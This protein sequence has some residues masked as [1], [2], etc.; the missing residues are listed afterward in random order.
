MAIPLLIGGAAIAS[1]VWGAKKHYDAKE[2]R[3]KAERVIR[4]ATEEFL[5]AQ[6]K[7]VAE[8]EALKQSA[9]DLA[10]LRKLV[11][12]RHM[13][14][15]SDQAS[16]LVNLDYEMIRIDARLPASAL[17]TLPEIEADLKVWA[18][19]PT[20]GVQGLALGLMGAA[21]AGSLATSI[22]VAST[23]TAI[24]SLSGVAATNA[25][26]AWL[27]GGSLAAGG[28][29]MAGG[30]AVLGGAVAGPLVAI[31][32][33]AA[34]KKAQE[35]LTQAYRQ[36]SEI[37]AATQDVEN[38]RVATAMIQTRVNELSATIQALI[39]RFEE[40]T[41]RLSSF[42]QRKADEKRRLERDSAERRVAYSKVN[43]FIRFFNWLFRRVPDFSY[44]NP[45]DYGNFSAEEQREISWYFSWATGLKTVIKVNIIDE[46]GA[47]TSES[48]LA[49]QNADH[50]LESRS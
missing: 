43:I 13:K 48:E 5:E 6:E 22:G 31:T 49:I 46:V 35:A 2:D 4:H 29:G 36:E 21:G 8:K 12:Q 19:L 3:D 42:V 37:S 33:M 44:Q 16:Q 17:P 20:S 26:L 14:A 38:A 15:F 34:A 24:S 47:L 41:A 9:L 40:V 32:G 11:D 30:M 7:L 18:D 39:P 28:M 45:M 23:G 27:G 1:A 50:L 10:S 25:T